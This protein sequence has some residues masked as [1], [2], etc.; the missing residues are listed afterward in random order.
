M[1]QLEF[2]YIALAAGLAFAVTF[3]LVPVVRLLSIAAGYVHRP[4]ADRWN[5]GPQQKALFGGLAILAGFW[6][7]LIASGHGLSL[8]GWKI[9]LAGNFAFALIGFLDDLFEFRPATKVLFQM[10]ASLVPIAL[11][12]R[13]QGMD[14]ILSQII[15]MAWILVVVNAVNLLDNMDGIAGGVATIAGFFLLLHGLQQQNAPLVLAA[16]ALVGSCV[17][18]LRYNFPP[19]SIFM[20]DTGSHLLGYTLAVL[21]LLDVAES[22]TTIL[23][24]LVGPTLVLVVPIFDTALVAL[25]R[26]S[27]GRS[28]TKGAPDHSSHRLVS[29]GLTERQ[30]ALFLYALS[31]GAGLISLVVPRASLAALAVLALPVLLGIY[32][33]GSFLS[34]V[35]IYARTPEGIAAAQEKRMVIYNTFVP[36]KWPLLDLLADFGVV[37]VAHVGAYL[38]RFEGQIEGENIRMLTRSL[39]IVIGARLLSFQLFG[40]YRRVTG[41]FSVSDVVSVAKAIASSSLVTVTILVIAFK[42]DGFS[43]AV[44]IIDAAL[45]FGMVVAGHASISFLSERFRGRG[46]GTIRTVIVGAG[47]L[48]SAAAGL[49]R[50]DP[51]SHRTIVAYLDDDP[52]K[53][54][55]RLN[56]IAVDGPIDRLEEVIRSNEVDEVVIATSRLVDE[57]QKEIRVLC[58]GMG[59]SVRRAILE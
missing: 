26:L 15:S 17:A 31:L 16:A 3:A 35:P 34:R 7:G 24:A 56:G 4:R 14:P 8:W 38:L 1:K 51:S 41:H 5:S 20:G 44:V 32:Y 12:L 22:K 30:T 28:V 11:G 6:V 59:L 48:G 27:S 55:R 25:N 58:E 45:A 33:F 2:P 23:I 42:F 9:L 50:R 39:P 37:L 18:F 13:I 19:S 29:L 36:H 54:G 10:V 40:L 53:I 52:L 57:R 49:L 43:R 47:D 21:T 46:K